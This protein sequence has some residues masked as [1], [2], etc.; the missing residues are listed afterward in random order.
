VRV[1]IESEVMGDP[2]LLPPPFSLCCL[3][4]QVI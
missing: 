2:L 3:T 4:F 1:I